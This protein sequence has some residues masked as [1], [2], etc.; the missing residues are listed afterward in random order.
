MLEVPIDVFWVSLVDVVDPGDVGP[1][2]ASALGLSGPAARNSAASLARAVGSSHVLL[3]LDNCEQVRA[4]CGSL[5]AELVESCP[6]LT[7]L[8]TSRLPLQLSAEVVYPIPP[9]GSVGEQSDPYVNDAT[10]LFMDRAQTVAP[11]Y[12]MTDLNARIV[13][14]ICRTLSGLPLAIELA[15]SWIR[16]LA[17]RELLS[18]LSEASMK[19]ATDAPH[20]DERHRSIQAVLD[21]SW[22]W[23]AEEQRSVL[24]ALGVF[25][26]G[27]TPAAASAVSGAD[28]ATLAYLAEL[29]LIQ[30]F[31]EA[32]GGTRFHVHELVRTYAVERLERPAEIRDWHVSYFL[33]LVESRSWGTPVE[34]LWS[35]PLGADLANI[36]AAAV[37]A[38]KRQDAEAAQRL[39]VAWTTSFSSASLPKLDDL[40]C[41]KSLWLSQAGLI[42][43]SRSGPALRRCSVAGCGSSPR[44]AAQHRK[45]G[46][47]S[48]PVRAAR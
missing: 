20:V 46:G 35:D 43:S 33:D 37:W 1:A 47:G 32:S 15:A 38:M 30:R 4:A 5:V 42:P 16:V 29:S 8:A 28:L 22:Q 48:R 45:A 26:G 44:S 39:A 41:W 36:E 21:S 12:R 14:D 10:A 27:F 23:L 18:H 19:L 34:P 11:L 17:P 2:M 6:R 3:V 24:A 9:L 40:P 13:A 7:V 31:P 25:V